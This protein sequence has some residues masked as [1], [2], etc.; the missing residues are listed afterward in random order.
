MEVDV[1]SGPYIVQD[2][3][4][5]KLLRY[6]LSTLWGGRNGIGKNNQFKTRNKRTKTVNNMIVDLN[7]SILAI[8]LHVSRLN[9]QL[10]YK[11]QNRFKNTLFHISSQVKMLCP[12]HL[13]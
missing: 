4:Q 5:H 12:L 2:E 1:F 6:E 11:Y 10:K 9:I 7:S 13:E 8:V 3:V